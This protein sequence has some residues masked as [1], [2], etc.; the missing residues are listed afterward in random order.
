MGLKLVHKH[1]IWSK[2]LRE[3]L[4]F[5]KIGGGGQLKEHKYLAT[6]SSLLG[7][8]MTI[9]FHMYMDHKSTI[10]IVF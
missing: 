7:K 1:P 10:I 4:Y 9:L 8:L 5:I 3:P 6:M 2:Y